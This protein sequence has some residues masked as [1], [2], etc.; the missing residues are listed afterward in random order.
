MEENTPA[1]PDRMVDENEAASFLGC[2]PNTLSKA[3]VYGGPFA[4]RY[5]KIGRRVTYSMR[6]L[7]QHVRTR[8]IDN[9]S[10]TAA[11]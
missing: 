5:C 10:Q 8:T 9:T 7:V 2:K 4:V 6:D 11:C 1:N 3:R